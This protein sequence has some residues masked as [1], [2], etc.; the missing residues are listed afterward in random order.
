MGRWLGKQHYTMN[1]VDWQG[2]VFSTV[3]DSPCY[4]FQAVVLQYKPPSDSRTKLATPPGVR[5]WGA[6]HSIFIYSPR[7]LDQIPRTI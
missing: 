4:S 5:F 7:P 1:G 6:T 3:R 2:T